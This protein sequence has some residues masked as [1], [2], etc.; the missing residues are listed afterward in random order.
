MA[1]NRV[2]LYCLVE[3]D[4]ISKAFP[5]AISLRETV[6]ELRS[7]IHL[8]K[9]VW[10][11]DLEAEDLTLWRVFIPDNKKGSA[12]TIDTLDDK[13]E[14]DDPRALLYELLPENPDRNT[15]ILVQE[16]PSPRA[17][18]HI[19]QKRPYAEELDLPIKKKIRITEGWKQYTASDGKA[20]DLPLA[21]I[22]ILS[23][24]Q[25]VPDPRTSFDHLKSNLRAGDAIDIPSLGQTPKDFGRHG[26]ARRVFVTEQMLG[27]WKEI[28]G[29]QNFIYRRVLSG[30]MGVGKS[31][32]SYF[33]AAKAYAEG[34]LVL[35]I[36]DAGVL[37]TE[38]EDES[39]LQLVKRFLAI[40]KDILTSAELE[41]L[42]NDYNGT[43]D[44]SR[45]AL[46]VIF[47]TLLMSRERKTLLLTDEHR[48]L[49]E[50]APY[51]PD[52]FSSLVPLSSYHWWQEDA[53]GS[54][55]IF[56]GTAHAKYEM[57]IL[58]ESYR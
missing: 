46:S 56:T 28:H 8:S 2:R 18:G 15:Y 43:R 27:L 54:R 20:V 26:P 37:D 16:V 21:W 33:L 45:N 51:V 5:L 58:D 12:I 41:M 30:P 42:I 38:S 25:F 35:Y 39:A 53:K 17:G 7:A 11:K 1:D 22:D 23:S 40:N 4:L 29:E 57:E 47:R 34:W 14:F 24:T 36:S 13:T 55:V 3:G 49:F 31:Y 10:F 52:K 19:S 44:I 48:K 50:R 6:A 9:P 32:L